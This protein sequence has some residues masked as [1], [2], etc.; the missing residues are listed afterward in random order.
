M[1][2]YYCYKPS[3][4]HELIWRNILRNTHNTTSTT[5]VPWAVLLALALLAD[6]L[7]KTLSVTGS[8]HN[9]YDFQ[10]H[11][12]YVTARC[13]CPWGAGASE[14]TCCGFKLISQECKQN[15]YQHLYEHLNMLL[16]VNTF[17]LPF[18]IVICIWFLDHM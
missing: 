1:L 9:N 15:Y 16:F 7:K 8:T 13:C 18:H 11:S 17:L 5:L 12:C 3:I 14:E 2:I 6:E 10:V 4:E